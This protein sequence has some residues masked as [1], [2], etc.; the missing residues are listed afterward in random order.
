MVAD[1]CCGV[2]L[3]DEPS[4][5]Y[6]LSAMLRKTPHTL[7]TAA[8]GAE[9][10]ARFASRPYDLVILDYVRHRQCWMLLRPAFG[11]QLTCLSVCVR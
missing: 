3:Q 6:V 8:D 9:A 5:L 11:L 4:N 1:G 7:D 10:L 2:C